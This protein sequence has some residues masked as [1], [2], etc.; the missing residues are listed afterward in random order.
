MIAP[1]TH[2]FIR[3]SLP[4]AMV[5]LVMTSASAQRLTGKLGNPLLKT[6]L[7]GAE[8]K[9]EGSFQLQ[10]SDAFTTWTP[11]TNF[12]ALPA[13]TNVTVDSYADARRFYRLVRLTIPPVITAQPQGITN[14][15]GSSVRLEATVAGSWPLRY[16]W[17]KDNQ[18][19]AGAT[20]NV[21]TFDGT[22]GSSGSYTLTA[23]SPWGNVTSQAAAV[24]IKYP[25]ATNIAGKTI[26]FEIA[27]TAE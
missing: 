6:F 20:S 24:L 2:P 1:K 12:N 14:Y 25:V 19:V 23:L 8:I 21:L 11:I 3:A 5:F 18:A 7:V 16:Q 9:D 13:T 15:S 22:L 10:R 4:L 27:G 26:H 17:S